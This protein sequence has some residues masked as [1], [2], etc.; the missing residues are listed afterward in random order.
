MEKKIDPVDLEISSTKRTVTGFI[1]QDIHIKATIRNLQIADQEIE[2]ELL[3]SEEKLLSKASISL[4]KGEKT[5]HTF[6]IKAPELSTT[7]H[8]RIPILEGEQR[9]NNNQCA[10]YL[11]VLTTKTRVFIAEGA[12]YWD[13]KFLAQH[14]R[15]QPHIDVQSVHR[16]ND[17]RFF[18]IDSK[19]SYHTDSAENIFPDSAEELAKFDLIIFGKNAEYFLTNK[20]IE[21]LKSFVRDQGGAILF[22]RGKSYSG[23]LPE[24]ADLEPVTWTVGQL[25]QF[26]LTPTPD[27]KASGLFGQALP[28]PSSTVWKS[29]PKLK[30]AHQIESVKPFTRVLAR[31]AIDGHQSTFPL[32]AV[33]RYGQGV[34]GI[35]NADG[36]WKWDFYPEARE[37]GN[38][39]S[40]F[41]SQLLQWMVA[42]SEFLPGYQYSLR[43]SATTLTHGNNITLTA[44]YRGSDSPEPPVLSIRFGSSPPQTL[45]PARVPSDDPIPTWKASFTPETPGNYEITLITPDKSPQ[46][47]ALLQ[48][49]APPK[50]SDNFNPDPT[51][52]SEI[53]AAT[54]G[55]SLTAE[56]FESYFDSAFSEIQTTTKKANATW[57]P[58]WSHWITAFVL[59]LILGSEWFIRRRS[60]LS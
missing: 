52:L 21:L 60:G 25:S 55:Q 23:K 22:S 34:T 18:R 20:R 12:P 36:L 40:E 4:V 15:L 14:L 37:L 43:S 27:G 13:S 10:V 38:M 57:K 9:D 29:L 45:T 5:S 39:Y 6:T 16:L 59:V 50:E 8:L 35:V 58:T 3:D 11:R 48:A 56:T 42:Y 2:I 26:S 7:V 46:P 51:F 41:W 32:L 31:G 24:L 28:N 33:R 30:D 47:T 19:K 53:A 54:K 1:G 49:I 17:S 44:R